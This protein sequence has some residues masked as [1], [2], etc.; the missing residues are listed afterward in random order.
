M[1]SIEPI[2]NID[3]W[4]N[5][6]RGGLM[7]HVNHQRSTHTELDLGSRADIPDVSSINQDGQPTR[8]ATNAGVRTHGYNTN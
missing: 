3:R 5:R 8:C 2:R 4:E 7:H 1:K 6:P